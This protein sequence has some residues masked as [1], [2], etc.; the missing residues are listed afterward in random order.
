[1]EEVDVSE[2]S[3]EEMIDY[4]VEHEEIVQEIDYSRDSAEFAGKLLAYRRELDGLALLDVE[5][6]YHNVLRE[7]WEAIARPADFQYW[8][9]M[10]G[11]TKHE[12]AALLLGK[13]PDHVEEFINAPFIEP[14]NRMLRLIDRAQQVGKLPPLMVP[15]CVLKWAEVSHI[16]V[17]A[18]LAITCSEQSK[19]ADELRHRI[20]QQDVRIKSLIEEND[21]L[22]RQLS[23][24]HGDDP[25]VANNKKVKLSLYTII[26]GL[27][28]TKFHFNPDKQQSSA[29]GN[30]EASLLDAGLSLNRDTIHDHLRRGVRLLRERGKLK[31][32][33]P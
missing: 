19:D 16:E 29:V 4:L 10:S 11:W 25:I 27:A 24:A 18:E 17:P 1:M 6:R 3:K 22:R 20:E 23:A 15:T 5:L 31:R 21:D 14:F 2:A 33:T 30:I 8:T 12:A 28:I 26:V 32:P 9:Q 13:D 7:H